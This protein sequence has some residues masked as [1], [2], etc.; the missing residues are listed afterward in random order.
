MHRLFSMGIEVFAA[1]IVLL[2]IFLLLN[3]V[4]FHNVKKT[5]VYFIFAVYL[6]AVYAVVGLPSM[7]YIRLEPHI[8]IVPFFDMIADYKNA[9]LNVILF[10]PLGIMLPVLWEEFRNM[11]NT[12]LFGF[13]MT[14]IIEILQIFTFR[15]T[16]INDIITNVIGTMFGYFIANV[17]IKKCSVIIMKNGKKSEVFLLGAVTFAIMFFIQ[18]FISSMIWEIVL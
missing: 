18:P 7:I 1:T 9:I 12:V 11:R 2:P 3:I 4:F 16:D 6:S 15:T 17:I 10:V 5:A 14:L 13:G 8:N